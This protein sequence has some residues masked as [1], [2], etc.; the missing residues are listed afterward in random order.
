ML[1]QYNSKALFVINQKLQIN[2]IKMEK[3]TGKRKKRLGK[4]Y[5]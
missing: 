3:E 4:P 2:M 1:I 5:E